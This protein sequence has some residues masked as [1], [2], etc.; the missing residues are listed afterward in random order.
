[1]PG[2]VSLLLTIYQA[3]TPVGNDDP[4]LF[5]VLD[6]MGF[7]AFFVA[8]F[9]V[10]HGVYIILLSLS[11]A[12]Q[13]EKFHLL[14]LGKLLLDFSNSSSLEL[15]KI[16]FRWRYIPLS[17][18][19]TIFEFKIIFALMRHTY[20]LPVDFSFGSYISQCFEKYSLR[21]VTIG[22]TG[23]MVIVFIGLCNYLRIYM[24]NIYTYNCPG[25][26]HEKRT[27]DEGLT[28]TTN[29]CD[30]LHLQLFFMCGIGVSVYVLVVYFIGRI[31][32]LRY[33]GSALVCILD[34]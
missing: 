5:A 27:D 32:T 23:W 12:K 13:Y 2:F 22:N 29:R 31:Y 7:F 24:G 26:A 6:F 25:F 15:Q 28:V 9:H 8:L 11:S 34:F 33:G 18:Y 14:N 30:A 19:R 20:S 17:T 1:M 3:L 4:N 21:V 10:G 16:F